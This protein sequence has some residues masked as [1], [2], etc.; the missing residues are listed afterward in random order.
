M[1]LYHFTSRAALPHIVRTGLS[2]GSVPLSP[3]NEI[4]AV[5]L[6]ADSDPAGHGVE[7]SG[8][9][10]TDAQRQQ[11]FEWTGV[12][13]P[14]GARHPRDSSVRITLD[15]DAGH[16]SLEEWLPWAR[17]RLSSEWLAQ[18]HPVGGGGDLRRAKSWRLFFGL[19][20]AESFVV[21]EAEREPAPA[22]RQASRQRPISPAAEADRSLASSGPRLPATISAFR[23]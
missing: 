9:L 20:P 23:S 4:N 1:L 2:R 18:L 17:R 22:L 10:M 14:A 16:S 5:W 13:P 3:V 11:A 12:M 7:R 19:I 15:I 21:V 6:T 8:P